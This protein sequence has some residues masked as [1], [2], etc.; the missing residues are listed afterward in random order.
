MKSPCLLT[1]HRVVRRGFTLIE[2]LL[3]V[4]VIAILAQ[5][6]VSSYASYVERARVGQ[7]VQDIAT[8]SLVISQYRQDAGVYPS[9][10]DEVGN[11]SLRDP[12]GRPYQYLN[13]SEKDAAANSRR[14]RNL[15]PINTDFDLYSL[16]KD[17]VS[18][19]QVTNQDSLDD[20]IRAND[21]AFIDIASKFTR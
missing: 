14:D 11:G 6:A 1:M 8:L 12:W 5:F 3:I 2:I 18:K 15:N 9:N 17:G 10:L 7:A 16:G 13:L 4:A 21:G 19:K 20:V